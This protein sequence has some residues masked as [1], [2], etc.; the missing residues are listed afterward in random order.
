MSRAH[1]QPDPVFVPAQIISST[2][3]RPTDLDGVHVA[4]DE[5]LDVFEVVKALDRIRN[6]IIEE[7]ASGLDAAPL[8]ETAATAVVCYVCRTSEDPAL[9]CDQCIWQGRFR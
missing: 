3:E 4:F 1:W 8:A 5:D 7:A 2:P 9:V 6:R